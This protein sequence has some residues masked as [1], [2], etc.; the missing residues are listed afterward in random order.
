MQMQMQPAEEGLV[1]ETGK[2]HA[3]L[4]LAETSDDGET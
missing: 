1:V 3:H 2:K 4:H